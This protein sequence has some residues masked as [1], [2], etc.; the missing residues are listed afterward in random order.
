MR[1]CFY[2]SG[3]RG[4]RSFTLPPARTRR[5][6]PHPLPRSLPRGAVLRL[7]PARCA[8][9][10]PAARPPAP[11]PQHPYTARNSR[12]STHH[13]H[14][15]PDKALADEPRLLLYALGQ[16]ALSGPN[17]A[18]QP[19]AWN[20]VESAKWQSWRQLGTMPKMEAM[21]LYVKSLDEQQ[22]EWWDRLPQGWERAAASAAAAEGGFGGGGRGGGS[23]GGGL[24]VGDVLKESAW[25]VI[26]QVGGWVSLG[27][28]ATGW[29]HACK[30]VVV[31]MRTE[32]A[33][34]SSHLMQRSTHATVESKTQP[35]ATNYEPT[36][37]P[38]THQQQDD[39]RKP[40]PRYEQGA[41]LLGTQVFMLGGHYGACRCC[42]RATPSEGWHTVIWEWGL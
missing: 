30:L 33:Q 19:W 9:V 42:G 10:L 12:P 7:Q 39:G 13:H 31:R 1:C 20:V 27:G 24:S 28:G 35:H 26:Q 6:M 18:P 25:V 34:R 22:P 41:A 17:T 4:S 40:L 37:H 2:P 3:G 29:A 21:R 23:R 8:L 14:H 15:T 5:S 32:G 11:P 38:N 16:Q 36:P